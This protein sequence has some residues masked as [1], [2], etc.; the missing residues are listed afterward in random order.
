MRKLLTGIVIVLSIVLAGCAKTSNVT[1]T[2]DT[3]PT[4][5]IGLTTMPLPADTTFATVSVT[6][7]D[8]S[9]IGG[10]VIGTCQGGQCT[11]D[12]LPEYVDEDFDPL[13]APDTIVIDF[14]KEPE[15][16]DLRLLKFESGSVDRE[17]PAASTTATEF[18]GTTFAWK[19]DVPTGRYVLEAIITWPDDTAATL[20]WP[21]GVGVEPPQE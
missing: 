16:A 19:P 20:W 3:A 17:H 8:E 4:Q 5:S 18:S 1:S 2:P 9:S 7:W 6:I 21:L 15:K 10:D 14:V 12:E 13:L 11:Q